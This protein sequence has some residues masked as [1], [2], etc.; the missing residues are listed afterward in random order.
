MVS[1]RPQDLRCKRSRKISALPGT[2]AALG[3]LA[4]P[5]SLAKPLVWVAMPD[6]V[7]ALRVQIAERDLIQDLAHHHVAVGEHVRSFPRILLAGMDMG[8]LRQSARIRRRYVAQSRL[9][10]IEVVVADRDPHS[11]MLALRLLSFAAHTIFK[12]RTMRVVQQLQRK[13]HSDLIPPD[14]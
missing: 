9:R 10:D 2:R 6:L 5:V 3:D 7:H 1:A 11:G 13:L 4:A 12:L 14:H 8:A